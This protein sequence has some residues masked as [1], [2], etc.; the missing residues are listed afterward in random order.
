MEAL[1][2]ASPGPVI[3]VKPCAVVG[4][5]CT[6]ASVGI[7]PILLEAT[8]RAGGVRGGKVTEVVEVVGR[9]V[10]KVVDSVDWVVAGDRVGRGE[11]LSMAGPPQLITHSCIVSKLFSF[12]ERC[13][14]AII[15]LLDTL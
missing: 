12:P 3:L 6:A 1:L 10:N 14:V 15:K 8:G 4:E 2:F 9:V 13:F 5:S 7:N 11:L